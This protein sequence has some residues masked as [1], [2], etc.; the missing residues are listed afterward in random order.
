M[1]RHPCLF[2]QPL[3]EAAQQSTTAGSAIPRSMMSPASSGGHVSSVVLTMSTTVLT[4]PWIACRTSS[5]QITMVYSFGSIQVD[6]VTM[7]T[8]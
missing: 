3:I 5:A 4:G 6:G 1:D 7:V 2:A 8:T